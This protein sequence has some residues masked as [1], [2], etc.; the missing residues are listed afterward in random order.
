VSYIS[1][2]DCPLDGPYVML[3]EAIQKE[4][5]FNCFA[6]KMNF[7]IWNEVVSGICTILS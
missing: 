7:K 5:D 4:I 2:S 3:K 6:K 1:H